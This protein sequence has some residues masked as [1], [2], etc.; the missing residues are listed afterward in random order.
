M[1]MAWERKNC[2]F[3]LSLKREFA[4]RKKTESSILQHANFYFR[5]HVKKTF[6]NFFELFVALFIL[7][8]LSCTCKCSL[9][10]LRTKTLAFFAF[11]HFFLSIFLS[12]FLSVCLSVCLYVCLSVYLPVCLYFCPTFSL[13]VCISA[14]TQSVR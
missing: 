13:S 2:L 4:L 12:F 1:T 10:P 9:R 6:F 14:F 3:A 8:Y 7:I 11:L 5:Q